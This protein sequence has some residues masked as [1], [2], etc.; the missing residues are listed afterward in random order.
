MSHQWDGRLKHSTWLHEFQ[1]QQQTNELSFFSTKKRHQKPYKEELLLKTEVMKTD[2]EDQEDE[3]LALQS[4]FTA[5]E[6]ARNESKCAGEIR[7]SAE[8]PA[9]FTVAMKE[10]KY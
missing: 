5:D 6:F 3:L 8:L 4:I 9:G 2:L 1:V 7:V 10:G